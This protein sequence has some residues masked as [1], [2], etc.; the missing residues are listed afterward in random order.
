VS[1]SLRDELRVVLGRDQM[2]LVRIGRQ[3]S[4]RGLS[5]RVLDKQILLC[6]A[7]KDFSVAAN[8]LAIALAALPVKPGSAKVILT[9]YFVRY[10]MVPAH[11]TL[12][13]PEEK[14]AYARH[15][16]AQLFGVDSE[17][18]EIRLNQGMSG[19]PQLA[20]AIPMQVLQG[21]RMVFAEAQIKLQS[22]QPQL[23]TAYNNSHGHMQHRD[24]WFVLSEQDSLCLGLLQQG[25]WC[26]VRNIK[27]GEDWPQRLPEI[28]DREVYLSDADVSADQVYLW[29]PEQWKTVLP[30]DS[31]WKIHKLQPAIRAGFVAG[32]DERFALAMC[33]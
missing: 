21:L 3:W 20:S 7:Q 14:A 4:W 24:S 6:A 26:S 12:V 17:E 31:R 9:N 16:F 5:Y 11:A 33:G 27:A 32:Y 19:K 28:L 22:V 29:A 2:Q 1:L 23:M 25:H 13:Q 15:V 8:Q 10:A 30:N 18:W